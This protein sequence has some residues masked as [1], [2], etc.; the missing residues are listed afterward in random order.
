[1]VSGGIRWSRTQPPRALGS[2]RIDISGENRGLGR[3]EPLTLI[4]IQFPYGRQPR[5]QNFSSKFGPEFPQRSN[6]E[7]WV[8]LSEHIEIHSVRLSLAVF[9]SEHR[10]KVRNSCSAESRFG[11]SPGPGARISRC[12]DFLMG[13]NSLN[14]AGIYYPTNTLRE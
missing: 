12:R 14:L 1:M 2:I 9:L 7:Y 8:A 4:R 5:S 13:L 6:N 3:G 10:H 11:Q